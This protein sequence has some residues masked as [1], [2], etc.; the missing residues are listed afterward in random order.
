MNELII[1]KHEENDDVQLIE[2]SV[3]VEGVKHS[4]YVGKVHINEFIEWFLEHEREIRGDELPIKKKSDKSLAEN[5][6]HSYE[7]LDVDDDVLVD[8]MYDYRS[9]HCLR[10]ASRGTD[11]PEI[12]IGKLGDSYEISKFSPT[13]KWQY[14]IDIDGFFRRLNY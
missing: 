10:F 13:E 12:Y 14:P 7:V 11:F 6:H 2:L 4:L 3:I 1:T 9:G 8:K 5:I